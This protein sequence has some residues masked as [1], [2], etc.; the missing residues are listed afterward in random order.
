MRFFINS[1]AYTGIIHRLL[2]R[3]HEVA[4]LVGN[5]RVDDNYICYAHFANKNIT[6]QQYAETLK[7]QILETKPDI[8]ICCKGYFFDKYVL[9]ETTEWIKKQVKTT[10]YWCQDDPFFVPTFKQLNLQRGYDIALTCD[11]ASVQTYK[12]LGI[13]NAHLWWPAWDHIGRPYTPVPE[14]QKVDCIFA[15]SPYR[16]SPIPRNQLVEA[17]LDRGIGIE[18]Y[19]P[20]AWAQSGRGG[21]LNGN[22]RFAPY[23]KGN[24]AQWYNVHT[25]FARARI[26]FSNH[27]VRSLGYLNDRVFMVMGV[28]GLLLMDNQPEVNKYFEDGK[29]V[30]YFSTV[31]DFADKAYYYLKN[32]ELRNIIGENARK[33]IMAEHTYSTRVDYLLNVLEDAGIK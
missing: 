12:S 8:Y 7:Q 26:N 14:N 21:M 3:G 25:L 31:K 4:G 19:G 28:G 29:E 5:D 6:V 24:W 33:K 2:E 10:I 23:Y 22:D 13:K 1:G 32:P 16:I 30:V 17:L 18:L 15:G 27:I 9:P 11:L 20:S